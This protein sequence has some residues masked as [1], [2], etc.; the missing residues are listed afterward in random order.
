M[1][2]IYDMLRNKARDMGHAAANLPDELW[3]K[4]SRMIYQHDVLRNSKLTITDYMM[5]RLS[6]AEL[7][8]TMADNDDLRYTI[9]DICRMRLEPADIDI[10]HNGKYLDLAAGAKTFWS[11]MHVPI[12]SEVD[13]ARDLRNIYFG[14]E[15]GRAS[16]ENG[17]VKSEG[18]AV[19]NDVEQNKPK[20]RS[21]RETL[22]DARQKAA[23]KGIDILSPIANSKK[24]DEY[25]ADKKQDGNESKEQ[26]TDKLEQLMAMGLDPEQAVQAYQN[27]LTSQRAKEIENISMSVEASR[28]EN[29]EESER[30]NALKSTG[31]SEKKAMSYVLDSTI[32]NAKHKTEYTPEEL[33]CAVDDDIAEI[34]DQIQRRVNRDLRSYENQAKTQNQAVEQE[35]GQSEEA[36]KEKR[37]HEGYIEGEFEGQTVRFKGSW[38]NHT[39]SDKEIDKLLAGESVV[40]TYTNNFNQVKEIS[41]KLEWQKYDGRE[42]LGF[43]PDYSKKSNMTAEEPVQEVDNSLF[44][45]QDEAAAMG[46]DEIEQHGV[47]M[48]DLNGLFDDE[49]YDPAA[50]MA[51]YEAMK[52]SEEIEEEPASYEGEIDLTDAD[53]SVIHGEG[54]PF[55]K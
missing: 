36:V 55:S 48:D 24:Q 11:E 13:A 49:L 39:F 14:I 4:Y 22:R 50:D 37:L 42:Y 29:L 18:K 6:P 43:K 1:A 47:S 30:I 28:D 5:G 52:A 3:D 54:L 27:I 20:K 25:D 15:A 17:Q 45:E 16:V 8:E 23:Q 41:G 12:P 21:F 10:Q 40:F 34:L 7:A 38:S 19:E 35:A 53:V 33:S 26:E 2:T 31:M 32:Q 46:Y 44:N 9:S 51:V